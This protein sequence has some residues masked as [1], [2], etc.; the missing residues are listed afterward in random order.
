MAKAL[1]ARDVSEFTLFALSSSNPELGALEASAPPAAF[2]NNHLGYALTWFG[3][4]V[5]LM[6]FYVAMLR[7]S[8]AQA[9]EPR[10]RGDSQRKEDFP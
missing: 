5:A 4:A 10:G 9:A 7:R 6:G 3:L 2:A 1:G 8:L